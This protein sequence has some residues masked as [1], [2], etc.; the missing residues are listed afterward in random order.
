[1]NNVSLYYHDF[2]KYKLNFCVDCL[3]VK[4]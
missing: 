1:L 3:T 2:R 4:N